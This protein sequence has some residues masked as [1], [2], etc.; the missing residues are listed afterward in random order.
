V[1]RYPCAIVRRS[2]TTIPASAHGYRGVA[3]MKSLALVATMVVTMFASVTSAS[4]SCPVGHSEALEAATV[5]AT[6]VAHPGH[7]WSHPGYTTI[8]ATTTGAEKCITLE[9]S[10]ALLPHELAEGLGAKTLKDAATISEG[11]R[12]LVSTSW[13]VD[14]PG[15]VEDV[16]EPNSEEVVQIAWSCDAPGVTGSFVVT[17]HG[18]VG[19]TITSS[20]QFG[21]VSAAWCTSTRKREKLKREHEAARRRKERPKREAEEKKERA[22]ERRQETSPL[23]QA[24]KAFISAAHAEGRYPLNE[25]SSF[26]TK[27]RRTGGSTFVCS[28]LWIRSGPYHNEEITATVTHEHGHYYVGPFSSNE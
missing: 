12:A 10:V 28:W 17:S 20:G 14:H 26:G 18:L 9:E 1:L 24:K 11:S 5:Q 2:R 4:A 15:E 6:A 13:E 23:G 21:S 19:P 8:S 7:T 3:H 16:D 27:C 25:V 22:Q